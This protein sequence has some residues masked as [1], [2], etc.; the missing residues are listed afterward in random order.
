VLPAYRNRGVARALVSA[1]G[2]VAVERFGA[3]L[4]VIVAEADDFPRRIY[5]RCGFTL[6]QR[7]RALWTAARD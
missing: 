2:R 5:E 6:F 3:A 7:E 1:A 4:L